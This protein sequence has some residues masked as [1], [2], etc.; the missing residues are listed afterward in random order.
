MFRVMQTLYT[1]L[2]F[3]IQRKAPG[4]GLNSVILCRILPVFR[5]SIVPY[6]FRQ[7]CRRAS[8]YISFQQPRL[9]PG[10]SG[11]VVIPVCM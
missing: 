6:L 7:V 11:N 8:W 4:L 1:R 5:T 2:G 3:G 9:G 10:L